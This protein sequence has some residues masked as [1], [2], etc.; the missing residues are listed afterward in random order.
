M[1]VRLQ[2]MF[3]VAIL[4]SNKVLASSSMVRCGI[5]AIQWTLFENA[6]STTRL[7]KPNIK[8]V[9][10]ML[11]PILGGRF[12][13]CLCYKSILRV[14]R[15]LK[16]AEESMSWIRLYFSDSRLRLVKPGQFSLGLAILPDV[17]SSQIKANSRERALRC[18]GWRGRK[19]KRP[20]R[21]LLEMAG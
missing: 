17:G 5:R 1:L 11:Q 7:L 8:C 2:M 13:W 12:V 15:C 19:E 9:R 18:V 21:E 20:R 16:F 4:L 6:S 10:F 3:I 14:F